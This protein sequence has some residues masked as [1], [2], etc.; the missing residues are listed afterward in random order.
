MQVYLFPALLATAAVLL[1]AINLFYPPIL[2]VLVVLFG[3]VAA[4]A[5]VKINEG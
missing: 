1:G 2:T 3:L 4:Y 5:I